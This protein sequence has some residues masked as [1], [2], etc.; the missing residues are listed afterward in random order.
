M[1]H[2]FSSYYEEYLHHQL[3]GFL[4]DLV[5]WQLCLSYHHQYLDEWLLSCFVAIV[6]IECGMS[7]CLQDFCPYDYV[8]PTIN[9]TWIIS[10]LVLLRSLFI[11]NVECAPSFMILCLH[12]FVC[13]TVNNTWIISCLVLLQSLFILN[14]ECAA[15][16]M[17]LCLHD[18]VCPTISNTYF[19]SCFWFSCSIKV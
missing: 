2:H 14:V 7:C 3:L 4:W 1:D 13:P 8:C 9:K 16:F 15:S 6:H 12:D 17:I 18:F 5:F 19:I 11:L 10:C